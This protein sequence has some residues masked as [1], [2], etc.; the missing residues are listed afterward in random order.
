M[1]TKLTQIDPLIDPNK[2]KTERR[3]PY[4]LLEE[5]N[6]PPISTPN[7]V[8]WEPYAKPRPLHQD[9]SD[10]ERVA[11]GF[12]EYE[13]R[14]SWEDLILYNMEPFDY[15]E[16]LLFDLW[17]DFGRDKAALI[18]F[19]KQVFKATKDD[20]HL[21]RLKM[22]QRLIGRGW[23]LDKAQKSIEAIKE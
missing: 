11:Y 1:A 21:R 20:P 10:D 14:L 12:I 23:D 6:S 18:N 3:Y 22:A 13:E 15:D 7:A 5:L 17:R 8:R 16:A 19:F 9:D 4:Y 2:P